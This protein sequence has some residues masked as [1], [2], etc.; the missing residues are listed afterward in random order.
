MVEDLVSKGRFC[1]MAAQTCERALDWQLGG[2]DDID[3]GFD[4]KV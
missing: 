3:L 2:G 4:V 1:S